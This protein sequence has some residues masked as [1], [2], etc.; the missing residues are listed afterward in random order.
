[1]VD[2]IGALNR[3]KALKDFGYLSKNKDGFANG[4]LGWSNL[5][6]HGLGGLIG[7]N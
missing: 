7:L 6:A 1:M 2:P 5:L 4:K 3:Q